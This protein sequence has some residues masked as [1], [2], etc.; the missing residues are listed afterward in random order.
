MKINR[1]VSNKAINSKKLWSSL[2]K[3]KGSRELIKRSWSNNSKE[4]EIVNEK[5]KKFV[6]YHRS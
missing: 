1:K 6:N 4:K 5:F 3:R 2:L